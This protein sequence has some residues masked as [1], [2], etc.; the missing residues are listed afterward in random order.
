MGRQQRYRQKRHEQV[1]S[2]K[3]K[4]LKGLLIRE[5]TE[6]Q[7]MTEKEAEVVANY[8]FRYV[9][10]IMDHT[11]GQITHEVI[12]GKDSHFRHAGSNLA[13]KDAVLTIYNYSDI[14]LLEEFGLK[15]MQ[16]N[17]ILRIIEE[18]YRQ[19]AILDYAGM[20]LLTPMTKKTLRKRLKSLWKQG[21]RAPLCGMAL[22]YKENLSE[23]R[24]TRTLKRYLDGEELKEIRQQLFISRSMWED[25]YSTFCNVIENRQKSDSGLVDMMDISLQKVREYR[26]IADDYDITRILEQEQTNRT[27]ADIS[28]KEKFISGLEDYCGFFPALADKVERDLRELTDE[29]SISNRDN[30]EIIYYAVSDHEPAGR[31]LSECEL[32]PV[33]LEYVT[34]K[35]EN[36][37]NT[38]GLNALKWERASRF[39]TSARYQGALLNQIDLAFL[40]GISPAVMQRL[41]K[42]HKREILPTRGNII[43]MGPKVSHADEIIDDIM[44]GYEVTEIRDRT[45][46][47]L[48]SIERYKDNFIK[49]VGL[50]EEGLSPPEI[51]KVL[52]CSRR[53]VNKYIELYHKYNTDEYRWFMNTKI[54]SVYRARKQNS[55]KK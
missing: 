39:A 33:K 29:V 8:C 2:L 24:Q 3:S 41:D 52:D 13:K 15:A 7:N 53:L 12:A 5:F 23:F 42:E 45:K 19:D 18:A 51:R 49:V 54:R 46:H 38:E 36:I 32:T 30:D 50:L 25:I 11:A 55:K 9:D 34:T 10:S 17:R 28:S 26:E 22:K 6:K 16:N 14:E 21:I 1:H 40:I 43:D 27:P 31:S 37:F 47:T 4:S 48:R 44:N 20:C 35:D